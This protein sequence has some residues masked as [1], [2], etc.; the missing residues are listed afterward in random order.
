M[1]ALVAGLQDRKIA[2]ADSTSMS[3]SARLSPELVKMPNVRAHTA[4]RQRG[5]ELR[6]G[7]CACGGRQHHR[8]IE[9][10]R[11]EMPHNPGVEEAVLISLLWSVTA[12]A[13]PA[14]RRI[15]G[16]A[17]VAEFARMPSISIWSSQMLILV[18]KRLVLAAHRIAHT[19][20][21]TRSAESMGDDHESLLRRDRPPKSNPPPGRRPCRRRDRQRPGKSLMAKPAGGVAF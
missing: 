9:G 20:G 12:L 4:S 10:K 14:R 18:Q 5:V 1:S 19:R 6:D 7:A 2:G 16:R 3:T 15:V 8:V 17:L 13:R 21:R 11:R